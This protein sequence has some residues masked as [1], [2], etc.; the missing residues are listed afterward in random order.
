[1]MEGGEGGYCGLNLNHFASFNTFSNKYVR[2]KN[3]QTNEE[4]KQAPDY[5]SQEITIKYFFF[6]K[7]M[8]RNLKKRNKKS[9]NNKAEN[10][11][12]KKQ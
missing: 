8:V 7:N 9:N 11:N 6:L 3:K 10:E 1:M 2:K 12:A 4:K 5:Q